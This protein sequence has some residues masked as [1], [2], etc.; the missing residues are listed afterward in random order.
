MPH[1]LHILKAPSHTWQV[2]ISECQQQVLIHCDMLYVST[3]AYWCIKSSNYLT[4]C[5]YILQIAF[6]PFHHLLDLTTDPSHYADSYNHVEAL[7]WY[8]TCTN[9]IID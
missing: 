5:S 1:I 4:G 7:M 8:F 6:Y 3:T 2:G 9:T